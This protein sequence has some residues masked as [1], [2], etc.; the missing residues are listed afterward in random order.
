VVIFPRLTEEKQESRIAGRHLNIGCH[1]H[2]AEIAQT[3][4]Q[5]LVIVILEMM[6]VANLVSKSCTFN[7]RPR[8]VMLQAFISQRLT[9]VSVRLRLIVLHPEKIAEDISSIVF[10][11]VR[12]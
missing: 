5:R 7:G 4:L 10:T 9:P 8:F 11:R 2:L 12:Y 3:S 1:K 6:I